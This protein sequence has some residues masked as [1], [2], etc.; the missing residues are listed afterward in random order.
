MLP[1]K[2]QFIDR[3]PGVA[4][5]IVIFRL[6]DRDLNLIAEHRLGLTE[7]AVGSEI[8]RLLALIILEHGA[9]LFGPLD[10][11]QGPAVGH[12]HRL[13]IGIKAIRLF[14]NPKGR[15]IIALAGLKPGGEQQI[16]AV[17]RLVPQ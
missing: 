1:D 4:R 13:V 16:G 12:D 7:Q 3:E 8:M 2:F 11:Q 14:I 5:Q 17:F 6:Q 10:I 9:G 15:L